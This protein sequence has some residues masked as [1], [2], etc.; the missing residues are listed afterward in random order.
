MKPDQSGREMT[1]VIE[2]KDVMNLGPP[3]SAANQDVCFKPDLKLSS[4]VFSPQMAG[5]FLIQSM[6]F[7]VGKGSVRYLYSLNN[8]L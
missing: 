6:H 5:H 2:R 4:Y 7:V 3:L 1:R 8:L